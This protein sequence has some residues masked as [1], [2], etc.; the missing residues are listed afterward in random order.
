MN[1]QTDL[2]KNDDASIPESVRAVL[3]QILVLYYSGQ[4]TSIQAAVERVDGMGR[5]MFYKHKKDHPDE[6][7]AISREAKAEA[8]KIKNDK[9]IA[10]DAEQLDVSVYLQRMAFAYLIESL[11]KIADIAKGEAREVEVKGK[12]KIIVPYPRDQNEAV[13]I[14]Q[15]LARGG[16][17]P[18]SASGRIWQ[19]LGESDEDSSN[20]SRLPVL[21]ISAEFTSVVAKAADG[22]T[23]TVERGGGDIIEGE[24][25][26]DGE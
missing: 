9:Q 19:M 21:P 18:E 16:V 6:F 11:P 25:V 7:E 26:D 20:E 2:T 22:T 3:K 23:V 24:V 17:L 15:Q 5:T 14:L 8:F 1:E 13:K 4:A 12:K 10:F